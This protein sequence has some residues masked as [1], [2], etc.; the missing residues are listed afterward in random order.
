MLLQS[1][2]D[3]WHDTQKKHVSKSVKFNLIMR[4]GASKNGTCAIYLHA[5]QSGERVRILTDIY[6]RPEEWDAKKRRVK[7]KSQ[8]VTDD[9][10]QLSHIMAQCTEI[11]VRY[12]LMAA[13]LT[14]NTFKKEYENGIPRVKVIAFLREW[15]NSTKAHVEPGTNRRIK[16]TINKFERWK[17]N[18]IF[19]DVTDSIP[20]DFRK[21]CKGENNSNSTIERQLSTL[22]SALKY[23]QFLMIKFPLSLDHFKIKEYKTNRSYLLPHEVVKME[24]YIKQQYIPDSHRTITAFFLF[25]CYTGRRLGELNQIERHDTDQKLIQVK[26]PKTGQLVTMHVAPRVQQLLADVPKLFLVKY[27]PEYIN[28]T[29]KQIAKVLGIA[30]PVSMHVSRHTF[31]TEVIRKGSKPTDLMLMLGHSRLNT[32]MIYVHM[33][34]EENL[35]GLATLTDLL[36]K[37]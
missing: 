33:V 23:A 37:D 20:N 8:R 24:E 32:S 12:R 11:Q 5:T 3:T 7:G 30:K 2:H 36:Y 22:R 29:L 9:N 1:K 10:L 27:S 15:H 35:A 14:L 26:S 16:S 21:W 25:G 34:D 6:C 19:A 4:K 18:L 31:A 28:K 13:P 17:P